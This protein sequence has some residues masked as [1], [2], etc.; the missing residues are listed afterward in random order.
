[1][2]NVSHAFKQSMCGANVEKSVSYK[3]VRSIRERNTMRKAEVRMIGLL[4][5]GHKTKNAGCIR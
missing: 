5:Q 3:P 4:E 2:I 1:M